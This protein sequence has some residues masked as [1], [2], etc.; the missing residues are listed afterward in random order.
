MT[1]HVVKKK[2]K[3][4]QICELIWR[5]IHNWF[6]VGIWIQVDNKVFR[7]LN[8]ICDVLFKWDNL[9]GTRNKTIEITWSLVSMKKIHSM[10]LDHISCHFSIFTFKFE[11][12]LIFMALNS[13]KFYSMTIWHF[14]HM[15]QTTFTNHYSPLHAN[16][17]NV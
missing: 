5:C 4:L 13:L 9:F 17:C 6:N 3:Q 12:S 14:C 10:N 15:A 1:I 7:F 16:M 8:H 2:K 11:F